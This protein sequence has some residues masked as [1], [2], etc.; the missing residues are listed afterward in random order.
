MW[1]DRKS[2]RGLGAGSMMPFGFEL[3]EDAGEAVETSAAARFRELPRGATFVAGGRTWKI[4]N[5]AM[6]HNVRLVQEA[7][8]NVRSGGGFKEPDTHWAEVVDDE[9]VISAMSKRGTASP[10]GKPVARTRTL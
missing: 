7:D 6:G 5:T 10:V 2:R 1:S 9:I 4:I 8:A 3:F